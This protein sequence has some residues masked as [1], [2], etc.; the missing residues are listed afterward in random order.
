MASS[1][2]AQTRGITTE[3]DEGP[4]SRKFRRSRRCLGYQR[5]W[6]FLIDGD[7]TPPGKHSSFLSFL[8]SLRL[9]LL[10]FLSIT[11]LHFQNGLHCSL[12]PPLRL[13]GPC[14]EASRFRLPRCACFPLPR[15]TRSFSQSPLGELFCP[16]SW[17]SESPERFCRRIGYVEISYMPC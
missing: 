11:P 16:P 17:Q 4:T 9:P 14:P 15:G 8:N 6:H 2:G 13:P 7:T 12:C 10:P 5:S 1:G 3:R